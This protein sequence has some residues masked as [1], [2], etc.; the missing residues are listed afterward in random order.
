MKHLKYLSLIFIT[1][2]SSS[3]NSQNNKKS[4]IEKTSN[5]QH[6]EKLVEPYK[7]GAGDVVNRGY[8][9]SS[10]NMWFTT[11]KEGV[12][13][14]DGQTF[15]NLSEKNGL[16]SNMVNAVIEDKNGIMWF[17]TAKGLCSYDGENLINI[18]LPKKK[19]KVFRLKPDC[20]VE[21]PKL[22]YL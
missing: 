11:L 7:Y 5:K 4:Q 22:F 20:Q 16:C 1:L 2:F 6:S 17:G 10:G 18:P 12:F 19:F 14:Y 13:K 3:C 9:D 21:K 15:T 8:L